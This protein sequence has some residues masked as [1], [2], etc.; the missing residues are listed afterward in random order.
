MDFVNFA[1]DHGLIVDS[2]EYDKWIATPTED[3][4]QKR[5][6]R[7]KI[8][9]DVGWVQNWST[10]E[11]PVTWFANGVNEKQIRQQITKSMDNRQQNAKKASS[12]AS[13][14]MSQCSLE[15]H[16][17]L[18]AK[19]F[20]N[21]LANCFVKGFVKLLAIPMSIDGV[22]VGCQ[23]I[24]QEG[25]KKFLNGQTTKGAS[26][27]IGTKGIPIFCEGFATGLSI[28][29]VMNHLNIPYQIHICF[30]ASNMKFI[31]RNIRHGFVIADNDTNGIG[32]RSAKDT[33]KP[34]W[35]SD[36]TGEDFNDYHL[37]L[38]KVKAS[39]SLKKWLISLKT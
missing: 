35:L 4:P 10:M 6:G 24:D 37:R 11:K 19:G 25:S 22:I 26:F 38:G 29:E 13:W 33:G 15:T 3:H 5:N 16:P 1:R 12:K 39:Q 7:Y 17:Y 23:L 36:T 14:I 27:V 18:A 20:E 34:Y 21:E 8:L 30:S 32:E 2:L 31:A 9:G 28:R